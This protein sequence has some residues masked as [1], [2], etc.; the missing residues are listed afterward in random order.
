MPIAVLLKY[1]VES[2]AGSFIVATESG[3]IHELQKQCPE[4]TFIPAPPADS[5]CGCNDCSFMKLNT[6]QKLYNCLF[7]EL[8]EIV[9][10]EQLMESARRPIERMPELSK[11]IGR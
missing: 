9:V 4:K 1:A 3:I 5:T 11:N 7:Y 2:E 8:P 10:D 6:L